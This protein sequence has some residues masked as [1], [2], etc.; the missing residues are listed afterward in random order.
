MLLEI[1]KSGRFV[2]IF[3]NFNM[4]QIVVQSLPAICYFNNLG[5][6][7]LQF[8]KIPQATNGKETIQFQ[9]KEMI[10]NNA[11]V[12]RVNCRHYHLMFNLPISHVLII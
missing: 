11:E 6:M 9:K 5:T 3:N 8:Q 7:F 2:Q 1:Q 10:G 12:S 4:S